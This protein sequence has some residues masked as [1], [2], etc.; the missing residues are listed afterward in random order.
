VAVWRP[1]ASGQQSGATVDVMYAA[2][3]VYR[4]VNVAL[5]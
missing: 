2:P 5:H 1:A 3:Q 4:I